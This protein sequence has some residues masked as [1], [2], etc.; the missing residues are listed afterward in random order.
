MRITPLS[1]QSNQ[2]AKQKVNH[3][4]NPSF[5]VYFEP[6]FLRAVEEMVYHPKSL[7]DANTLGR[8]TFELVRK[9]TQRSDKIRVGGVFNPEYT[10]INHAT[11]QVVTRHASFVLEN[12]GYSEFCG[13]I[14][15]DTL[16]NARDI[17]VILEDLEQKT[18]KFK[19]AGEE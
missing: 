17:R 11:G 9:L 1:F 19:G 16:N 6:E 13:G 7:Y 10:G 15:D 5:G 3:K 12:N 2:P 14:K 8:Y 4:N 18:M